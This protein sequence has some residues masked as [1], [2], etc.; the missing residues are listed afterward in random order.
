MALCYGK[1][2]SIPENDWLVG[3]INDIDDTSVRCP[4]FTSVELRDD[5]IHHQVTIAS[6]Q[7]YKFK[8]YE[9]ATPITKTIYF[10]RDATMPEIV[11]RVKNIH[12]QLVDWDRNIPPELRLNSFPANKANLD[13]ISKT[14]Q[15]QALALQLSYDNIQLLLHRPLLAYSFG[16]SRSLLSEKL[17]EDNAR[18]PLGG[19]QKSFLPSW[20]SGYDFSET[21]KSQCWQS[22]LRTSSIGRYPSILQ[23][24]RNSHAAAYIGIQTFAAGVMLAMFALLDPLCDEAKEAKTG[25]ARLIATSKN[26]GDGASVSDQCGSILEGLLRLILAEEVKSMLLKEG[27]QCEATSTASVLSQHSTSPARAWNSAT[28][29]NTLPRHRPKTPRDEPETSRYGPSGSFTNT[30][31]PDYG[32]PA[33]T[34]HQAT[35]ETLDCAASANEANYIAST[36]TNFIEA[37]VSMQNGR[38]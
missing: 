17:S 13:S 7:R 4:G 22:A 35:N 20:S 36:T 2:S 16:S 25:I 24:A 23:A 38:R 6:Y 12:Q 14:F 28:L 30:M 26:V 1:P 37:Q 15:L 29:A 31:T 11:K 32:F 10:H 5:G 34:H 18:R 8:L 3:M 21:T 27:V 33:E 9:I 19:N